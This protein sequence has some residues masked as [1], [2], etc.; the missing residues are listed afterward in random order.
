MNPTWRARHSVSLLPDMCV[1]SSPSTVML[2][3]DGTS[4]PPSKFSRVVL[5]EPL[6]PM[7]ADKVA[8]VHIQIQSLKDLNF[9]SS[10]AVG[11][12]QTAHADEA[13]RKSRFRRHEPCCF[14]PIG[15]FRPCRHPASSRDPL[16]T[17]ESP[18][19]RPASTPTSVPRS[20]P[21]LTARRSTAPSLIRYTKDALESDRTALFGM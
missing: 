11:L 3:A 4:R 7:N 9:F 19:D 1:I 14:S 5:P 17:M 21:R 13:L 20:A 18:G 8:L 6:G 16:T 10:A 15:R 2:P 12:V